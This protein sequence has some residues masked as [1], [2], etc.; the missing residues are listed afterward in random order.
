MDALL[1]E[2]QPP[3]IAAVLKPDAHLAGLPSL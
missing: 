3:D 1:R 2:S